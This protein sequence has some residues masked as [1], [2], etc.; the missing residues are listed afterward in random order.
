MISRA[1]VGRLGITFRGNNYGE[2][3]S[4]KLQKLI[5]ECPGFPLFKV[6]SFLL[7]KRI[8][9]KFVE[10]LLIFSEGPSAT[11]DCMFKTHFAISP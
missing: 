3:L 6:Y 2:F 10:E 7:E 5:E 9:I 1:L 8:Q 11:A 4:N